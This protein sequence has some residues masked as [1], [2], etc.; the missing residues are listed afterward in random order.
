MDGS[1]T[2]R[3]SFSFIP[4][5]Y[6]LAGDCKGLIKPKNTC[7]SNCPYVLNQHTVPFFYAYKRES[8][9]DDS[10]IYGIINTSQMVSNLTHIL[11]KQ[12][13]SH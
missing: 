6:W 11:T 9:T 12:I 8:L 4:N 1:P 10:Q 7:F 3:C 5:L 13:V 2:N